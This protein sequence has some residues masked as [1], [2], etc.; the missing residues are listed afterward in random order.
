V[1]FIKHEIRPA[2]E[3]DAQQLC[4]IYNHYVRDTV[5]TFDLEEKNEQDFKTEL[6]QLNDEFP[7]QVAVHDDIVLGYA[8]A[9]SWKKRSAYKNTVESSIYMS[10]E[11]TS[12][13]IGYHLYLNLVGQL[14]KK[15]VHSIIAGISLPNVTSVRLHEKVGFHKVAHFREVGYKF[16][17]WV[18]V[19]YW[20]LLLPSERK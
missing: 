1:T 19:G 15:G 13:G 6:L 4:D 18:D 2:L 14:K 10:P 17:K 16:N 12:K 5:V 9:N 7:Y 3:K 8:Y 20:E 11:Y